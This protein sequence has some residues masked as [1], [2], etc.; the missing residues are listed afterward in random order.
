MCIRDRDRAKDGDQMEIG[1]DKYRK[2]IMNLTPDKT[3]NTKE[4]E[5][6][7]WHKYKHK[8][9]LERFSRELKKILE[10]K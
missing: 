10:K 3:V 6:A 4:Y 9:R 5:E 2:Y 8:A 7:D 1:T